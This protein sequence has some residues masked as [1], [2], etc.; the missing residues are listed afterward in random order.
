MAREP[1]PL[2][3]PSRPSGQPGGGGARGG[4]C[5]GR[6]AGPAADLPRLTP[7]ANGAT[8]PPRSPTCPARGAGQRLRDSGEERHREERGSGTTDGGVGVGREKGDAPRR[9]FK[10]P[11]AAG[12]H[13]PA[14]RGSR[15]LCPGAGA[16]RRRDVVTGVAVTGVAAALG[17][18][19]TEASPPPPLTPAAR[20]P[21]PRRLCV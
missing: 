3:R 14:C 4:R 21:G 18:D 19:L 5:C 17:T 1:F 7:Y 10:L 2:P 20:R 8:P 13:F 9:T 12:L 15:C 6:G 16:L 11:R